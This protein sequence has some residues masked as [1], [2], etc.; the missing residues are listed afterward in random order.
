MVSRE[1]VREL[2]GEGYK[3]EGTN[4]QDYLVKN[5]VGNQGKVLR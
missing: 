2:G 1:E 4:L 3:A 5:E